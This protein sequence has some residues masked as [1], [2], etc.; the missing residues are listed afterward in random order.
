MPMKDEF[1]TAANKFSCCFLESGGKYF[2]RKLT[3]YRLVTG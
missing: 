3:G 2:W 1:Q